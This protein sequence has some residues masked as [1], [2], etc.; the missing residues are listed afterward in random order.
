MRCPGAE[1]GRKKK[2][3]FCIANYDPHVDCRQWTLEKGVPLA[4]RP[5]SSHRT[6]QRWQ[7][8]GNV[9]SLPPP[10]VYLL[11]GSLALAETS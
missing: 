3:N 1:L 10:Q 6:R 11:L 4:L 8:A 7:A 5:C 9:C 2:R